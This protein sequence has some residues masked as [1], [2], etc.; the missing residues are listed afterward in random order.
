MPGGQG[1]A[2]SNPAIP[3]I[4]SPSTDF[5]RRALRAFRCALRAFR[6]GLRALGLA[7]HALGELLAARFTVPFLECLRRDFSLHQEFREFSALSLALEWHRRLRYR[8]PLQ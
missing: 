7:L 4:S 6:L 1:A 5:L 8:D 3:T 2:G